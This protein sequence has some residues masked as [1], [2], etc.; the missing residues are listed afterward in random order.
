MTGAGADS[1]MGLKWG[2]GLW[3]AWKEPWR[4]GQAQSGLTVLSGP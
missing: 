1:P 2:P 4:A 3:A